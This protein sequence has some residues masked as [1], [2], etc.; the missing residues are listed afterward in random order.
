MPDNN[1]GRKLYKLVEKL[2]KY[3]IPSRKHHVS[4]SRMSAGGGDQYG[5]FN[6][7]FEEDGIVKVLL[8]G[9]ELTPYMMM[10][11]AVVLIA[12]TLVSREK[13]AR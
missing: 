11:G 13:P 1:T 10:G 6:M 9:E 7:P 12:M 8:D 2:K 5:S 4:L 3:G